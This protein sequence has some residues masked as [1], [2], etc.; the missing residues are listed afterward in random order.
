MKAV[1]KY[2]AGGKTPNAEDYVMGKGLEQLAMELKARRVAG[3]SPGVGDDVRKA[4]Q[5]IKESDPKMARDIAQ[6]AFQRAVERRSLGGGSYDAGFTA[7]VPGY[8]TTQNKPKVS[9]VIK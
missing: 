3:F 5:R 4:Y 8:K 2:Q 6:S 9:G 1:K 7:T